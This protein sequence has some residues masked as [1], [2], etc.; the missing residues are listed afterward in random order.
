[1]LHSHIRQPQLQII[2]FECFYT[3][4]EITFVIYNLWCL[5]SDRL[6][7]VMHKSFYICQYMKHSSP[8]ETTMGPLVCEKV[9]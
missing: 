4:E 5:S 9:A 2:L 1:M 6:S 7:Y 3:F 8:S